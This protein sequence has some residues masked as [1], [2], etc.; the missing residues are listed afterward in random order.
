[1]KVILQKDIPNIGD[2]GEIKE[3]K[4]G[5]AR[6]FLIPRKM[7]L[8]ATAGST[9][10]AQHQKRLISLKTEKRRKE[11]AQLSEKLKSITEIEMMI[12]VGA[13]NRVFGSITSAMIAK[14][15]EEKTEGQLVIDRRK[16]EPG[17]PIKALGEYK[18][19]INL[20]ADIKVPIVVKVVPHPDSDISPED[21]T[22]EK[23]EA[24]QVAE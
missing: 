12:R 13:K 6:N 16:I 19:R 15:I 17:D 5:Y 24:D 18:L 20:A 4:D 11:M 21:K 3:V 10:A 7:V 9:R 23:I 1:M 22:E 8:P 14:V 2:A